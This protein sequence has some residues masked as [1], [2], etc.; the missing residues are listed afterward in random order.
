MLIKHSLY[1]LLARGVPGITNLLATII[2]TRIIAPY[3]YGQYSMI[4][5]IVNICNIVLFNWIRLGLL[6]YMPSYTDKRNNILS[7]TLVSFCT[8]ILLTAVLG[9]IGYFL[10]PLSEQFHKL[11]IL[12]LIMLWAQ[13]FFELNLELLRSELSPIKYGFV[14]TAKSIITLIFSVIFLL[15]GSGFV[16][17]VWGAILGFIFSFTIQIKKTW[18]NARLHLIDP[19]LIKDFLIYGL[20]LTVIFSF[21]LII[22]FSDRLFLV[23][24]KGYTEAGLYSVAY[25]FTQYTIIL[26]MVVINLASYPIVIRTLENEGM[27][28]AKIKLIDN[29][30]LLLLVSLPVVLCMTILNNQ[31]AMIIFGSRFQET[32]SKIIP[33][34]TISMFLL[35]IKNYYFDLA[36][37]IS[38]KTTL[39]I[40]PVFIGALISVTLNYYLVPKTGIIGAG[41]SAIISYSASIVL[42]YTIGRKVTPLPIPLKDVAKIL[43]ATAISGLVLFSIRNYSGILAFL[44]QIITLITIYSFCIGLM[45]V[46]E[47]P[48]KL[49]KLMKKK[50]SMGN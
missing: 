27:E 37:Q 10:I 39:Q 28:K 40:I 43:C 41:Y 50:V 34:V 47:L 26:I 17:I 19:A 8:I 23:Y 15:L 1:Y 48:R 6:R 13:A 49:S 21:G 5:S 14:S 25:D 9:S 3:E 2:Y 36:F 45:N 20:P 18:S 12:I 30:T 29:I 44:F 24:F 38:K 31:I 22:N 16:G 46:W 35:G 4:L 42:S 11:F 32:A 33:V 7:T